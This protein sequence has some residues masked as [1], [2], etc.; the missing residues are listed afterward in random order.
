MTDLPR[1]AI[2]MGDP[3][4]IGPEI[5]LKSLAAEGPNRPHRPV[6]I[7]SLDVFQ[8]ANRSCGTDLRFQT[9]E[10]ETS[11]SPG[12]TVIDVV[13][14]GPVPGLQHGTV[15]APH[16]QAA[17]SAIETACELATSG[18]VDGIVTAPINKEALKAA[19]STHPGHT[20]MLAVLLGRDPEEVVTLFILDQMRVFFLTR[21][22][23][24]ADAISWL[25]IDRVVAG[26]ERV[27]NLCRV[28][29]RPQPHIALAAINPH[30][31][32]NGLHGTEEMHV[33]A[34]AIEV[35]RDR[36]IDVVGPVP[37][38]SVYYQSR[39]G[40]YD[41]VIS[42]YHDQGHIATKTVDFFGTVS[43]TLGLPI[44]RTSVD[45]GT[46]FDIAGKWVADGRGQVAA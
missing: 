27:H 39:L 9:F 3:A 19:G 33:L 2:T 21:H 32:E 30:G 6:L 34:P 43:A 14:L 7:G 13:D 22:L 20:E 10:P 8:Q 15:T 16:G 35:A 5:V 42:P 12:P 38:D 46:A 37:A 31:G 23:S 18:V 25:T 4:G 1:L 44:I 41:G 17:V 28:I 45:H 24:L 40:K 29:G 26:I 36:G 11:T